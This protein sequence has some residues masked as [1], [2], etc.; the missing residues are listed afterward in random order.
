MADAVL[1]LLP[2]ALRPAGA[3]LLARLRVPPADPRLVHGDL[4]PEHLRGDG[5]ELTAVI[6]W[7]DSGLGDPAIDLAW[8]AFGAAPAFAEAVLA[9]YGA[10][11][12]LV[13]RGRD[14]HLVGPWHEVLYGLAEGGPAYVDSGLEGAVRRLEG[15]SP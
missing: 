4:G 7:G 2:D 15:A 8:T 1:P 11:E 6:D 14:F 13:A 9:A 5:D 3:A 12:A 10:D